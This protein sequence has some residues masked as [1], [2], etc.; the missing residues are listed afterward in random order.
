MVF[1]LVIVDVVVIQ[2]RL[3]YHF[4]LD[5]PLNDFVGDFSE[6]LKAFPLFNSEIIDFGLAQKQLSGM[7]KPKEALTDF[8]NAMIWSKVK[9]FSFL[10]VSKHEIFPILS[11]IPSSGLTI[12]LIRTMT[13][14]MISFTFWTSSSIPR[15]MTQIFQ[16]PLSFS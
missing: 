7:M 9:G 4:S 14:S 16:S 10:S 13:S 1:F 5:E 2:L 11:L 8:L 15:Q 12:S 3:V 6:F